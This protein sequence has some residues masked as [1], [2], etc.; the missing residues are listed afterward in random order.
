MNSI[1]FVIA[2]FALSLACGCGGLNQKMGKPPGTPIDAPPPP[3]RVNVPLDPKLRASAE[4]ELTVEFRASDPLL[5]VHS[6]EAMRDANATAHQAEIVSALADQEPR[7]RFAAALACGE[8][9]IAAA[10][11]RLLSIAE[12]PS[13]NVRVAVR[14]ALHKLGDTSR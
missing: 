4:R 8:M 3:P 12:D 6:L 13:E 2:A 9:R 7:V 10:R 5:R 14:F 1:Q 11:Q